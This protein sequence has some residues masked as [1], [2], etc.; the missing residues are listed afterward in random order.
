MPENNNIPK[1]FG[2]NLRLHRGALSW[3]SF[4]REKNDDCLIDNHAY[5]FFLEGVLLNK[6]L[7]LNS[8]AQLDFQSLVQFFFQSKKTR[9]WSEFEGEF[10]GFFY[11][12]ECGE[13][14]VFTNPI[15]SQQVFYHQHSDQLFIDT[16]LVRLVHSM[17]QFQVT[18]NPSVENLLMLLCVGNQL[19]N[20]TPI[21]Q[22]S[23]I[24]DG[25]HLH[26]QI[27][28]NTLSEQA[29]FQIDESQQFQGSKHQALQAIHEL[30]SMGVGFE[31][32]KDLEQNTRHLA[33]LSGG[34]DS[35]MTLLYAIQMGY[36]PAMAFCF[37][38]S[39]YWD[40]TISQNIAEQF[41]IPYHFVAL[42]GGEF[43]Q[44]IDQLALIAEG[45]TQYTGGIHV[46]YALQHL[47]FE[48]F[49]LF[50]SGHIGDGVL[51]GLNSRPKP[52]PPSHFKV[53]ANPEI[54]PLVSTQLQ[55]IMSRYQKEEMFLIRNLAYN[56]T[57]LGA[58]VLQ[59]MRYQTSPFTTKEFLKLA[60]SLPENWK[61]QQK[62]Y[63]EWITKYCPQATKFPWERTAL[64]PNAHWKTSFGERYFKRLH[65]MKH[66]HWDKNP[67]PMSMA[68]YAYYFEQSRK[69]Q[70]TYQAYYQDNLHRLEP[71][72]ELKH[73]VQKLYNTGQFKQMSQAINLLAIM[74]L[75]LDESNYPHS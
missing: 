50:H 7:L 74:K 75:F 14:W 1:R 57:V 73:W 37:S 41:H 55:E 43:L 52:T 6:A 12:K 36:K 42:D 19:E 48:D 15:A 13:L 69:L 63:I 66:K 27:S 31:F 70:N 3:N 11:E 21:D 20:Q 58:K 33:L 60:I 18:V 44:N 62:I 29:Y 10:R 71:Y 34:L 32:E 30:F 64:L 67:A 39:N 25:H 56:R 51:G 59:Q 8:Y 61:F 54:L 47:H 24:R 4:L 9:F 53:V 35:R 68:P 17:Y 26:I 22:V 38:H 28:S 65:H 72:P 5:T 40:H 45:L 49:S 16:S 2:F 46:H 23:K